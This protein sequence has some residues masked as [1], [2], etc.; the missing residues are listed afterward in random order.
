[1][2]I[3]KRLKIS[4]EDRSTYKVWGGILAGALLGF[5]FPPIPFPFFIFFAFIPFLL[6]LE[7]RETLLSIN[8]LTYM[9]GLITNIITLYWVGSWSKEA[10]PF[11]MI[12]GGVLIFFNPLLFFI[13]STI[14][15]YAKKVFNKNIALLLFPLFWVA[16]EYAYTITEFRFPWLTLGNSVAYFTSYIQIADI[17]GVHGLSLIILYTNIVLYLCYKSF[18]VNKKLNYK[19]LVAGSLLI[20]IPVGYGASKIITYKPCEKKVKVGLIQPNLNPWDKWKA[21]SVQ[22]QLN[23]Y[24]DLSKKA[25]KEGAELLFYPETALPIYLLDG[26]HYKFVKQIMDFTDSNNV[27][28][29]TG[30][31]HLIYFYGKDNFPKNS[32]PTLNKDVSYTSFNSVLKF[33]PHYNKIDYYGKIMLVPFGE[34]VPYAEDIPFI[35]DLIKWEVGISSWNVGKDT[36]VF[37]TPLANKND[38]VSVGT[39]V[40]IESIYSQ[41]VSSFVKKGAEFIAVVTNDSWYGNSSGPYQHKSISL[42]RAVENRRYVVRAANG[43]ISC[44]INSLG[45]T[46]KKSSMYTQDVIVGEIGLSKELTFYTKYPNIIIAISIFVSLMVIVMFISLKLKK[47]LKI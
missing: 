20:L 4:T 5:S 29:F 2:K 1:M 17:I 12:S 11:L 6:E 27:T 25:T 36:V 22:T 34:K 44:I 40:C 26:Q 19:T 38:S 31:P 13:P 9:F 18:N 47:L 28:I 15:Y 8:K 14:Y 7:K 16:Y 46:L 37:K 45:E 41:F 42:I 43:G 21:G 10:D 3:F 35:G 39:V 23:M 30:M 32:K 24:F 33:S